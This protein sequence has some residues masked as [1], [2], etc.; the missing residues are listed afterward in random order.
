MW[1]KIYKYFSK[2]ML[3]LV[4]QGAG[5]CG[6]KCSYPKDYN[7]PYELFL[8]VDL[9]VSKE[10]LAFY[11]DVIQELP[12]LPTTCF[13]NSPTVSPMW[14]HYAQNHSGFVLEFDV[15]R[16][17]SN[18]EE[19]SVREVKYKD[20]P[21][22]SIAEF[23][24]R[25]VVTKKPRH[26]H[27]LQQAV[28]S[29][30]YF[31]KHTS[32]DYEQECRL[33]DFGNYTEDVAGNKILYVPIECVSALIVGSNF[34]EGENA[35]SVEAA[36]NN[37][38]EWYKAVIGRTSP[39]PFFMDNSGEAFI[40]DG[41]KVSQPPSK[42]DHCSEPLADNGKLC[43]WCSITEEQQY[44]MASTNPFRILDHYGLLDDYFDNLPGKRS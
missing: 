2:D 39:V 35:A 14:A 21:D 19:I 43:A 12:Q 10:S 7:D 22:D 33:V 38:L 34:S 16:L 27:F 28:L 8:G 29:E 4:S 26:A 40:F 17:E 32:W 37:G 11:K 20:E 15:D 31:T 23:L 5:F 44:N 1:S 36:E 42:C 41:E 25:A 9:N 6:I 24:G 30:A 18:F 13:S 3:G